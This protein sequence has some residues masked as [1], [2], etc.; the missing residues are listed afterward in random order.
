MPDIDEIF[1]LGQVAKILGVRTYRI[2][3]LFE[4]GKLPEPKLRFAG[5]RVFLPADIIKI[6]RLL[7]V[8]NIKLPFKVKK[9]AE[10]G[11]ED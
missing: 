1:S 9:P 10:A 2:S 7:G 8:E 3:F 6:A 4:S 11:A 5:K